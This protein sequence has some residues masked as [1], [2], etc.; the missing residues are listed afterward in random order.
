MNP[1]KNNLEDFVLGEE[2]FA[3]GLRLRKWFFG[4]GF[5]DGVIT[6]VHRVMTGKG[7]EIEFVY[8]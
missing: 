5:F 1:N 2:I 3:L 7:N 4:Y 6:K 8:R